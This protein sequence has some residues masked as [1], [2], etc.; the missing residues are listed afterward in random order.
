MVSQGQQQVGAVNN[1]GNT[2]QNNEKIQGASKQHP[3]NTVDHR[4]QKGPLLTLWVARSAP[5]VK[6]IASPDMLPESW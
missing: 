1:N 6:S 2:S 4:P 3:L 5:M